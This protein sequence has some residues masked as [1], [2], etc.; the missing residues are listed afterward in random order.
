MIKGFKPPKSRLERH[1]AGWPAVPGHILSPIRS[2][3]PF[4][5]ITRVP[6]YVA[7]PFKATSETID[8]AATCT[9][10]TEELFR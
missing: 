1:T 2:L 5:N 10:L 4:M 6:R 9:K 8:G 7:L 3:V